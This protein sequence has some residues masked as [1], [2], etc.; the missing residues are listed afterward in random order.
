[1]FAL[2]TISSILISLLVAQRYSTSLQQKA[3]AD[4]EIIANMVELEATDKILINDHITLQKTLDHHVSSN[5][6]IAY[7]FIISND[8]ILAHT[9]PKGVPV[10]LISANTITQAGLKSIQKVISTNKVHYLDIAWPIFGGKAGI[11]RVGLSEKSFEQQVNQLWLEIILLTSVILF[12]ALFASLFFIKKLTQPLT[13]LAATVEKFDEGQLDQKVDLPMYGEFGMLAQSFNNMLDRV[14]D[15]TLRLKDKN[16]QLDRAYTQTRTSFLISQEINSL[17]DLG[18]VSEYLIKRLRHVIACNTLYVSVFTNENKKL[19][20]F[21]DQGLSVL[22]EETVPIAY[23]FLAGIKQMSFVPKNMIDDNFYLPA[24]QACEQAVIFPLRHE[25]QAL[26]AVMIACPGDCTCVTKDLDVVEMIL[27]QS[28]G[29]LKR[30]ITHEEEIDE[31][32][33]RIEQSSGFDGLIGKD[34]KMQVIYKLI[35]DVAP[36]DA[37][38]LIQGES[39]TGKELV[40]RAIHNNSQRKNKPFVVINCSAYPDTLLESELFG[41]EKGAFTGAIRQKAGRFELA[42]GGTVFLDEIGEIPSTAQIKLLRILQTQKFERLGGEKTLKVN[43]RILAATNRDLQKE[44]EVGDFREDLFYRLNVIPIQIPPLRERRNDIPRLSR[45][46]LQIFKKEQN[47]DLQRFSS[48]AMRR[49]L[50]YPWPG[51]VREL[52]N[53]IE[54]A[55]VIAKN[56]Y[57]ELTD[58]PAAI[59]QISPD[60]AHR[61]NSTRHSIVENEKSLLREVLNECDWNKKETALKLGISRSTLYEKLKKYNIA[62]PTL[63]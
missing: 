15:F 48:E 31:L 49:L 4:A 13:V 54:H 35:E 7:L 56:K 30:A 5:S 44:V 14:K 32:R 22:Q 37:T 6:A 34:A 16:L 38:V 8:K 26:G 1:M 27:K 63:H 53:S 40:A 23:G 21:S 19:N 57:V 9:F 29:A 3:T 24:F 43:T 20:V 58:L 62:K 11:L 50:D 12:V 36:T 51:N 28:S 55:T 52:E 41:H 60:V 18:A 33:T 17:T 10:D 39:G 25:D 2:V 47:K 42:D 46:F 45:H 59:K 61:F